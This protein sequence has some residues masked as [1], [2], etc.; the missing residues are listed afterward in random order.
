MY[1]RFCEGAIVKLTV[2]GFATPVTIIGKV[3]KVLPD[4]VELIS[5][6]GVYRKNSR[7]GYSSETLDYFTTADSNEHRHINRQLIMDWCY[8]KVTDLDVSHNSIREENESNFNFLFPGEREKSFS[9]Y[10][11]NHFAPDGYHRGNGPYCG[12]IK[13][14]PSGIA[15]TPPT[16]ATDNE[17]LSLELTP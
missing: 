16:A 11:L 9:S 15:F 6:L 3:A 2:F 5:Q 8:A 10:T 12:E 17:G 13:A 4:E 14:D 7:V 1:L